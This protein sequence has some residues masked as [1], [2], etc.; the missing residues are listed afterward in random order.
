MTYKYI[1]PKELKILKSKRLKLMKEAETALRNE[2]YTK[3]AEKFKAIIK[4][5]EEMGDNVIKNEFIEKLEIL[6]SKIPDAS[7]E[8]KAEISP[9]L[10][11]AFIDGLREAPKNIIKDVSE[12]IDIFAGEAEAPIPQEALASDQHVPSFDVPVP[13]IHGGPINNQNAA[14]HS[15]PLITGSPTTVPPPPIAIKPLSKPVP[16]IVPSAVPKK[17]P[18]VPAIGS[19]SSVQPKPHASKPPK[20]LSQI[21]AKPPSPLISRKVAPV[22]IK[23][24]VTPAVPSSI[25]SVPAT[26]PTPTT[27]TP[28]P[29]I[30]P[31]VPSS[32]YADIEEEI[33]KM[34]SVEDQLKELKEILS[35]EQQKKMKT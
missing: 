5:S 18:I 7:T 12:T 8:K 9:E 1:S 27:T 6:T 4:I 15:Q 32:E 19:P 34:G 24:K 25:P 35:K 33:K 10:I 31:I 16:P 11:V 23:P 13:A 29:I 17:P 20:K 21:P 3:V 26:P 14:V 2:L 28:P 30:S 22:P